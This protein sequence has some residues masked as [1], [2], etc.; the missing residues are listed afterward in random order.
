VKLDSEVVKNALIPVMSLLV[1]LLGVISPHY[2]QLK[3]METNIVLKKD[4]NEKEIRLKKYEVSFREK[5]K[6]YADLMQKIEE[7][8]YKA[9]DIHESSRMEK[10]ME[11]HNQIVFFYYSIE[12][13]ISL[14]KREITRKLLDKILLNHLEMCSVDN[15]SNLIPYSLEENKMF[16]E[17]K[18]IIL[19]EVFDKDN[20]L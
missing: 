19:E 2:L 12:P 7:D 11:R 3:N 1:A 4:D 15:N 9:G 10:C 18:R 17:F 14:D 16:S 20:K 8:Y 6:S 13:F 5:Q